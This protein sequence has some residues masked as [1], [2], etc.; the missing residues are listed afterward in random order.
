[1]V[2]TALHSADGGWVLR[3]RPQAAAELALATADDK[4]IATH[5]VDRTF[6]DN[7]ERWVIDYKS[8]H[9]G[10]EA[11]VAILA[12]QAERY[13]PQLERYAGLFLEEGMPVRKAVFFLAHG[14]LVELI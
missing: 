9:F 11:D 1:M 10:T 12:V 8:A 13:R 4:R 14:R 2:T 5:V 6:I 7:N 3:H